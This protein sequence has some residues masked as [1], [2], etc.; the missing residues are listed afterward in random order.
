M[1]KR[2]FLEQY[3]LNAARGAGQSRLNIPGALREAKEAFDLIEKECVVI[4][5]SSPPRPQR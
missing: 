5:T 1:S 2:D 4:D 3:V